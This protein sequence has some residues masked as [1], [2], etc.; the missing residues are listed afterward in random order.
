MKLSN[1]T[2]RFNYPAAALRVA[3]AFPRALLKKGRGVAATVVVVALTACAPPPAAVDPA[4]DPN[5]DFR[6]LMQ[7]T[8]QDATRRKQ[9]FSALWQHTTVSG[10]QHDEVE[11]KNPLG[12]TQ[13]RLLINPQAAVFQYQ[14][15]ELRTDTASEMAQKIF[16]APIP[17]EAF[18]HWIN[19]VPAP[20]NAMM[21]KHGN[22]KASQISQYGWNISYLSYDDENRP[23]EIEI[24]ST[25]GWKVDLK[26]RKWL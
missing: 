25:I 12:N 6:V 1:D 21:V 20:G 15:G 22:G 16:G 8:V 5:V 26:I 23:E 7:I 24:N 3:R 17:F 13:A 4:V 9:R 11:I 10:E 14:G 18:H 19:G 2:N